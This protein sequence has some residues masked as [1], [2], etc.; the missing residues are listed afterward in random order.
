MTKRTIIYQRVK[1]VATSCVHPLLT[2]FSNHPN[3]LARDLDAK[4]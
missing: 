1:D 3:L 4:Y 2:A